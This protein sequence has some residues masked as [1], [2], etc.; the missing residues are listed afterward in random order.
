[1]SLA[2]S[3]GICSPVNA[4]SMQDEIL[5][6]N[7]ESMMQV[8]EKETTN[9][10]D[11]IVEIR[12]AKKNAK[13]I[14]NV[15]EEE[16]EYITSDAIESELLY[17]STL[18]TEVLKD[19]YCYSDEAID[20]LRDYNGEKLEENP[21]LRAVTATLSA[22]LGELVKSDTRMGV[23]YTWSWDSKPLVLFTDYA[24]MSW[25]GTYTNGKTNNMALDLRT[26]FSTV[27]YYYS[28]TNQ[29]QLEFDFESDNL[30]HGAAIS[31][32]AEKYINT[33]YYWAKYGSIFAY[34]DLV[35]QSA[36]GPRLYELNTHAEFAHYIVGLNAGVSFPAGIS[37]SFSGSKDIIGVKNLRLKP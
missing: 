25:E 17:R 32:P 26:S 11:Y 8:L 24:A 1:M 14:A 7:L 31:F 37:I 2:L 9:E 33:W 5:T 18:P 23:I 27:N 16:V 6:D 19:Q 29:K 10:Y 13:A 34:T 30:Y 12:D 35:D 3:L 4:I 15:S 20:V 22:A 36:T 28:N 21:E